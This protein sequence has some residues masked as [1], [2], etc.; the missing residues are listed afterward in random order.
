MAL[1]T[2]MDLIRGHPCSDSESMRQ[3][4][5][6]CCVR[7]DGSSSPLLQQ[8]DCIDC[9]KTYLVDLNLPQGRKD[10]S[11]GCAVFVLFRCRLVGKWPMVAFLA[12][13]G[14]ERLRKMLNNIQNAWD[15]LLTMWLVKSLKL[16]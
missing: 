8:S 12:I 6:W 11:L 15:V 9:A 7:K 10:I 13:E 4:L 1:A 2:W 3:S 5:E 14:T 16:Q